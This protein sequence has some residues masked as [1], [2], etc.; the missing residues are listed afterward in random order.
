MSFAKYVS[1]FIKRRRHRLTHL[2][3][4]LVNLL[5]SD[6]ML[7]FLDERIRRAKYPD[8][9]DIAKIVSL[10]QKYELIFF[11]HGVSDSS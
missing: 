10:L 11:L 6:N 2:C 9:S 8:L 3:I 7:E 1:C 5:L 4:Q